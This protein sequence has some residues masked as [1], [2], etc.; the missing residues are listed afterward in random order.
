MLKKFRVGEP[1][2]EQ[3]S[4]PLAGRISGQNARKRNGV[5]SFSNLLILDQPALVS[6]SGS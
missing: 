3:G 2:R 6:I 5:L 4:R 1:D